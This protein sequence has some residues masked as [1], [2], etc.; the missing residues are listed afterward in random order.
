MAILAQQFPVY[1][2][3]MRII[4]SITTA[5]PATVTTT[6]AHQYLTGTICRLHI[7]LGFGMYQANNL[8]APITVTGTTT[9]TID[10][11]TTQ[12]QP[13]A[14][15]VTFPLDAQSAV[16]VPIGELNNQLTAAVQNVLPYTA[17]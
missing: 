8:Y 7:P 16:V 3:A 4:A 9:F 11:D 5:N 2:P 13:F 10:I 14:A 6:F 1:Q 12:F 15:P 17:T